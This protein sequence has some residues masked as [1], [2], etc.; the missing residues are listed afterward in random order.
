MTTSAELRLEVLER[1]AAMGRGRT[2]RVPDIA[3]H[4]DPRSDGA[5]WAALEQLW[6]TGT[7]D[8]LGEDKYRLPTWTEEQLQMRG[9]GA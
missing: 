5:V 7:V 1:M 2:L 6:E 9:T 4:G 3:R 8:H